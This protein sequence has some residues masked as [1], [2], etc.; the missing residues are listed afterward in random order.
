M[1]QCAGAGDTL[2]ARQRI[3][4]RPGYL[5]IV[6]TVAYMLAFI[7]RQ[8]LSL[9]VD[10]IRQDLGISDVQVSLLQ[11]I[12]FAFLYILCG[13]PAGRLADRRNRS[14]MI[15]VAVCF[16]SVMTM[17]CGLARGFGS[18]FLARAGVGIGES[19]LAPTAYSLLADAYSAKDLPRAVASYTIGG[20]VGIGL[21]YLVGGLVVGYVAGGD[22]VTMPIIGAV[23]PWQAVFMIVGLPGLLVGILALTI[24]EPE[25]RGQLRDE[26]N[27]VIATVSIYDVL[28]FMA[29]RWRGYTSLIAGVS[30]LSILG[31]GFFS[32]YPTFL[33]RCHGVSPATAGTQMGIVVIVFGPIGA[34]LAPRI[35]AYLRARGH[36]DANVRTV[37][38]FAL[39]LVPLS[40]GIL[41]TNATLA[42]L[43]T[44][45]VIT[46]L[47]G[48]LG[49]SIAAL[50]IAT[51]NQMRAFVAAIFQLFVTLLGLGVGPTIVALLTDRVF[52]DDLAI[53]LSLSVTMSV[54]AILAA[55][56]L[57]LGLRAY[58]TM[59]TEAALWSRGPSE[60]H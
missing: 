55:S 4:E 21:A 48:Y 7:D 19:V 29:Q 16:W 14:V 26:Q 8:I 30:S 10:P 46:I 50:Q 36:L 60:K 49:L 44:I 3:F 42:L 33:I 37:L 34:I 45:P 56:V 17:A 28:R 2:K 9:L 23:K 35:A 47:A 25:R 6:L 39:L 32:W 1:G 11:G 59:L 43:A 38:C 57:A 31:Y 13:L 5:L 18:L 15:A 24:R 40:F 54:S 41:I 51:P 12:A 27:E 20:I 52:A 58:R 53:D 22:S